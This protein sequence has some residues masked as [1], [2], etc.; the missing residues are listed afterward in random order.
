MAKTK[1]QTKKVARRRSG[2]NGFGMG[3]K[4]SVAVI[5][6]MIPG[7]TWGL[8]PAASGNWAHAMERTVAAYTGYYIPERRFRLDFMARGLFPLLFG[9]M[10]HSMA[11]KMGI[12]RF[13]SRVFPLPIGI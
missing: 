6:G 11:N 4:L 7:I 13:I 3:G 8:E 1:A 9:M 5:A 12:N 2:G 10:A